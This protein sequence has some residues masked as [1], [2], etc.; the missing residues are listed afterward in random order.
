ML[1]RGLEVH[2][3]I[4]KL[5]LCILMCAKVVAIMDGRVTLISLAHRA[6]MTMCTCCMLTYRVTI[7]DNA[8]LCACAL[9]HSNDT[10]V[11]FVWPYESVCGASILH[12]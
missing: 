8:Q 2:A 5:I 7:F 9:M 1:A 4:R 3:L 11:E 6:S 10:C 12:V